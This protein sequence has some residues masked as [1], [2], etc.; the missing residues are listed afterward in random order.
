LVAVVVEI[1]P[2]RVLRGVRVVLVVEPLLHMMELQPLFLVAVQSQLRCKVIVVAIQALRVLMFVM[3]EA[4]V[5]ARL[6]VMYQALR[7]RLEVAARVYLVQ[8]QA[9]L[10]PVVVAVEA[11]TVK[12]LPALA[13][14][15]AVAMV[16]QTVL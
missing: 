3:V 8:L 11:E 2:V 16:A 9:L 4:A 14:Q 12:Q 13:V 5:L 1:E 7:R 10:L 6:V 15:V